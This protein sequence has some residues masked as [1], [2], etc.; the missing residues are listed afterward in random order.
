MKKFTSYLVVCLITISAYA[1]DKPAYLIFTDSGAKSDYA[2]MIKKIAEADVVFFG[3]QHNCPIAHWLELSVTT[4]LY[5]VHKADFMLGAEMFETDNQLILTEYVQGLINQKRFEDEAKLWN[6]YKTDYKALV[7]FARTNKVPFV[8]T[9]VPRRYASIVASKGFDGLDSL[10]KEAKKLMPR[11]PI[12]FDITLP[13]YAAMLKMGGMPG[14]KG[15][16]DEQNLPKAQAL[17]D[18]TMAWSIAESMNKR[19]KLLHFNGAYHSNGYEG[20]IWYLKKEKSS[21][22]VATIATVNQKDISSLSDENKGIADFI[23]VVPEDMT[24]TY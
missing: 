24:K 9:N 12:E 15:G 1:Q 22:R 23:I 14:K 8:A 21:V 6:N 3:E 10:S 18:A 11:L 19:T 2:E 16:P 5:A 4:D 20:I 7:E 13:G 17:K